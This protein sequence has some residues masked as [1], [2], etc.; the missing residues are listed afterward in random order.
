MNILFSR[1]KSTMKETLII[2]MRSSNISE[3]IFKGLPLTIDII[4]EKWYS[5]L[6]FDLRFLSITIDTENPNAVFANKI[7]KGIYLCSFVFKSR[8]GR[9]LK[10]LTL[11]WMRLL[12][13]RVV[14]KT[15]KFSVTLL[16]LFTINSPLT[17]F[18]WS[19][20]WNPR[21]S[22]KEIES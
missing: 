3:I 17:L 14:N 2:L 22:P 18:L 12:V 1:K 10:R 19:L 6:F 21:S 15:L 7:I 8:F 20:N 5:Q 11:L 9:A 13:W 4:D 16:I